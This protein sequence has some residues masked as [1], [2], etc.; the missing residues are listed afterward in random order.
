VFVLDGGN[1][2]YVGRTDDVLAAAFG[3]LFVIETELVQDGRVKKSP[4][5]FAMEM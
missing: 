3:P 5:V 1:L 2:R 4:L